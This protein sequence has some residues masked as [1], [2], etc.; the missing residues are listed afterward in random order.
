MVIRVGPDPPSFIDRPGRQTRESASGSRTQLH[1]YSSRRRRC[2]RF[3]RPVPV[4][5]GSPGKASRPVVWGIE[6]APARGSGQA[7]L[8]RLHRQGLNALLLG[9]ARVGAAERARL[10]ISARR[11]GMLVAVPRRDAS[12]SLAAWCR[13]ERR[14]AANSCTALEL[15]ACCSRTGAPERGGFRRRAAHRPGSAA[16]PTRRARQDAHPRRRPTVGTP[17]RPYGLGAG[18]ADRLEGSDTGS[19]GQRRL[20]VAALA[21]PVSLAA[22]SRRPQ[23]VAA[24][25]RTAAWSGRFVGGC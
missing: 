16:L 2:D 22:P 19:R 21:C 7:D 5:I 25:D 15:A 11:L 3:G 6:L 4:G 1:A 17:A 12:S 20:C 23:A 10:T 24:S 9:P 13:A 18:G 14:A 8:N